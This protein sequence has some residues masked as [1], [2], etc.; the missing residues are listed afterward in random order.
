MLRFFSPQSWAVKI[1]MVVGDTLLV[2]LSFVCAVSIK[3]ALSGN[4]TF[5]LWIVQNSWVLGLFLLLYPFIFYVF[6]L[7]DEERWGHSVRLLLSIIAAMGAS[8]CL[9]AVLSYLLFFSIF[10]GR[11]IIGLHCFISVVLIFGWRKVYCKFILSSEIAKKTV[12]LVGDGNVVDDIKLFFKNEELKVGSSTV[13][14]HTCSVGSSLFKEVEKYNINTVVI[15]SDIA[16]NSRLSQELIDLRFGGVSIFDAKYYFEV[17]T[18]KVPVNIIKD[19]CLVFYNH[20]QSFSPKLYI[21]FKRV[22][23]VIFSL[24]ILVAFSPLF[25]IIIIAI[26]IDSTGPV[27]FRQLR[28]GFMGKEYPVYKFRTMSDNAERDT[29]P[30]WASEDDHRVTRVGKVLRKSHLD[31]LPQLFN[32]LRGEMSLVGPRPIRKIFEDKGGESIPFYGLRHLAKPGVT[33]W[34]QVQSFDPRAGG[35]P[36]ERLQYDLFYLRNRSNLFDF[37]ILLK[38]VQSVFFR[39]GM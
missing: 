39:K 38:T 33:G 9:A 15:S 12:L 26:R 27:F 32:I 37:F 29:G 10:S 28:V 20:G 14:L 11:I 35:G 36:R 23:D 24:L 1:P 18:G 25:L 13:N 6:E 34:A 16:G 21:K 5:D 3:V 19:A 7:Y 17:I 22:F 8:A 4:L 31:E 30:T 2:F